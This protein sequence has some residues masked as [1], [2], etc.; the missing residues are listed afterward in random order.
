MSAG[1]LNS[2]LRWVLSWY[3]QQDL[4]QQYESNRNDSACHSL[5]YPYRF[6]PIWQQSHKGHMTTTICVF[7]NSFEFMTRRRRS[8][9]SRVSFIP[10]RLDWPNQTNFNIE[11][12]LDTFGVVVIFAAGQRCWPPSHNDNHY[13]YRLIWNPFGRRFRILAL[14]I[15]SIC[16]ERKSYYCRLFH[17]PNWSPHSVRPTQRQMKWSDTLRVGQI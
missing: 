14:I 1:I 13:R 9:C 11:K 5:G 12:D 10:F 6:S 2:W 3:F 8:S 17:R 15:T 7:S 16:P 4:G